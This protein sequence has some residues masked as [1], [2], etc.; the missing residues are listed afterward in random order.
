MSGLGLGF[1]LGFRSR[2]EPHLTVLMAGSPS[3]PL[4]GIARANKV[5]YS[6]VFCGHDLLL[7]RSFRLSSPSVVWWALFP[8][9]G[10]VHV[11]SDKTVSILSGLKHSDL[12]PPWVWVFV[13]PQQLS[14]FRV[15]EVI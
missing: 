14:S 3:F 8:R 4:K 5:P 1:R 15:V 7:L 12:L 11:L 2:G 13:L 9:C 6:P 10:V